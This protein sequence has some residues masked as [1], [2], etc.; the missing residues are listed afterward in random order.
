[1]RRI[2]MLPVVA[3]LLMPTV[4]GAGD[5]NIYTRLIVQDGWD[6]PTCSVAS[7]DGALCIE[8]ILETQG[9]ATLT[10][11]VTMSSTVAVTGAATLSSTLAVT[12]ASTLSGGATLAGD[13][14]MGGND[15][16]GQ[17]TG[18]EDL[19]GD[20]TMAVT[21]CGRTVSTNDDNRVITLPDAAAGN[22]GCRI[23]VVVTAADDAAK[24][25]IS[26]DS[27]D[28]IYG[29]CCGVNDA[30]TTACVALSGTA[31]KDLEC[32]KGEQNKGDS[33]TL[34]SDGSTGW[35]VHGCVGA[36]WASES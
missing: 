13:L 27:G 33:V 14:V 16:G 12:G 17:L 25:S 26:P 28:G 7:A 11:A 30:A 19:T 24:V 4:A 32:Q 1:M 21:D 20:D 34:I 10:G 36:G 8:G 3:M 6:A 29:M 23:T 31:D 5:T 18:F 2:T 22:L 9:A 35:Y 15:I